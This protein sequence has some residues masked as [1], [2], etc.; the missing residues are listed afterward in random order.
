MRRFARLS[1][2]FIS[3]LALQLNALGGGAACI[4]AGS[5]GQMGGADATMAGMDM[6]GDS[7]GT[8]TP[9]QSPCHQS[10]GS[11][12]SCQSMTQ[13]AAILAVIQ[14]DVGTA[15]VSAPAG[16]IALVAIAPPS[17]SLTPDVPP[18]KA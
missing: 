17:R 1:I 18:P 14:A 13:C 9:G 5:T 4:L 12:A 16:R 2:L 10:G 6:A 15:S 7:H 3:F 11:H 8:P